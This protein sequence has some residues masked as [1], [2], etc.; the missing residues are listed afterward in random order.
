MASNRLSLFQTDIAQ[1]LGDGW[2][3]FRGI[4]EGFTKGY[5]EECWSQR[6]RGLRRRS[7]A[8]RLL[9]LWVRIPS[10]GMDVCLLCVVR[11]RSLRRADHSS[12]GVLLTVVHR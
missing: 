11:W 5:A 6:P 12:R 2:A 9:R 7:A 8:A 10:G 3:S 4:K 1:C